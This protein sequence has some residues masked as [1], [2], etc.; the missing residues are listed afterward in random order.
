MISKIFVFTYD[1]YDSITTSK[2][3]EDEGIEHI[4]LCH[5]EEDKC[6]FIEG[7]MVNPKRII[8]TGQPK[9]L[10]NNR[11]HAL[12]ML[13]KDEWAMFLVDDLIQVT[14]LKDYQKWSKKTKDLKIDFE[15]QKEWHPI[16]N[17][18]SSLIDLI[19]TSNEDI[20][21]ADKYGFKLIGFSLH[22]NTAYRGKHYK[23][24]CL[25]DGRCWIV[26]KSKVKF[27]TNV[28]LIDDTCFTV[29]NLIYFG[30]VLVN[31]WA[32]PLCKR[33]TKGAYGTL[34]E[35]MPQKIKEVEYLTNNY[36][37]YVQVREKKGWPTGSHVV[38]RTKKQAIQL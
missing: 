36:G 15:N 19:K 13:K 24:W 35:R 32:L 30:G 11:N 25:A 10:A 5:T 28:Q 17:N 4:V 37:A 14:Q 3:L 31:Q 33:Y 29:I 20:K 8:A 18:K 38:I 22:E 16:L 34:E 23:T 21:I 27:D 9:G 6:K 2:M 26:K 12:S 1:R 7:G